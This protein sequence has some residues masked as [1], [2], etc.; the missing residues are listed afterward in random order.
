MS[1]KRKHL[2][3]ANSKTAIVANS[4]VAYGLG[5]MYAI[6]SEFRELTWELDVFK[7]M[8]EALD[9]IGPGDAFHPGQV[10][11]GVA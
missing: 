4:P 11:K 8:D 7:S 6:H 10:Q 1:D 3:P 9:W 2:R 5:M